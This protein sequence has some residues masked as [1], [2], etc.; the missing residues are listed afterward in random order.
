MHPLCRNRRVTVVYQNLA[1]DGLLAVMC[2]TA[3]FS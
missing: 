1:L 2:F 3:K